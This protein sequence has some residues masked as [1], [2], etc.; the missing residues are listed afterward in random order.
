MDISRRSDGEV[1][2]IGI[3]EPAP[4]GGTTKLQLNPGAGTNV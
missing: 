2:L 3:I 1:L 4:R